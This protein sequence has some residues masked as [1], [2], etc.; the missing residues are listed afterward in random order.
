M[1]CLSVFALAGLVIAITTFMTSLVAF[2]VA[3]V[4][5]W[6]GGLVTLIIGFMLLS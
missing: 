4:S 3:A 5:V 1:G 2:V 6:M